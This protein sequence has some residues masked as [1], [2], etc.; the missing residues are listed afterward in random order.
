MKLGRLRYPEWIVGI[1]GA[2]LIGSLFAPWYEAGPSLGGP[3][4]S[5]SG[6]EA[7][8]VTDV[9]LAL[10]GGMG[11][12]LFIATASYRTVA[13]PIALAATCTLV[14]IV[15]AIFAAVALIDPPEGAATRE[16]GAY[17]GLAAVLVLGVAAWFATHIERPGPAVARDMA[18]RWQASVREMPAPPPD[19][20]KPGEVRS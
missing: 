2:A 11:L 15:A 20:G 5:I 10:A 3:A 9:V 4:T 7:F 14:A 19:G 18:S 13:V 16:A 8:S 12:A 1:S 17:L 6:W